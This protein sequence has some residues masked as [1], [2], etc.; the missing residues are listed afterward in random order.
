MLCDYASQDVVEHIARDFPI[1]VHLEHAIIVT[2]KL[3][4][5]VRSPIMVD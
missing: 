5:L 4:G 1:E 2:K 3:S